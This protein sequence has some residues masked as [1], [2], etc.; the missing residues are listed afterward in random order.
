MQTDRLRLRQWVSDD[1][2]RLFDIR[3]RPEVSEWLAH[4]A[5]WVDRSEAL[6][7]IATWNDTIASDAPCGSWAIEPLDGSPLAGYVTLNRLPDGQIDVGWTLH[8]DATGKGWASEAAALMLQRARDAGV[9]KVYAVMW[10]NNDASAAVATTIGMADLGIIAD[11][12]YGT[13]DD[14]DSRVFVWPTPPAEGV[15]GGG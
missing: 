11:P 4:P 5:P 3:S 14:P 12:W 6:A 1:A 13:E 9:P 8:P 2:D 7:T 15:T 10:P